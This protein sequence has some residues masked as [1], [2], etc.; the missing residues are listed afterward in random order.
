MEMVFS[1][2]CVFSCFR[3]SP[4]AGVA[5]GLPREVDEAAGQTAATGHRA[6]HQDLQVTSLPGTTR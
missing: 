1:M 4:S 3:S 6:G 2:R 5:G